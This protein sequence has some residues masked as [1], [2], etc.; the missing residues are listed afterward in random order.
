[1][2]SCCL[3]GPP[4]GHTGGQGTPPGPLF[5][6]R[7][8]GPLKRGEVG[9][10]V[11]GKEKEGERNALGATT[12]KRLAA[13]SDDCARYGALDNDPAVRDCPTAVCSSM[14]SAQ[15][16]V[17]FGSSIFNSCFPTLA[18]EYSRARADGAFSNPTTTS[19]LDL[20]F[21][22]SIQARRASIASGNRS[23]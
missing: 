3:P 21:P 4:A 10:E 13:G 17:S 8:I 7:S 20:S 19:S 6:S 14:A 23:K 9:G 16:R 5:S 2:S 22:A 15:V 1:M 18:P 11:G 12:A